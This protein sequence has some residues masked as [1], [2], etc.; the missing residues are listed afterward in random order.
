[1]MRFMKRKKNCMHDDAIPA[2]MDRAVYSC[3][4]TKISQHKVFLDNIGFFF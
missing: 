3:A 2:T 4:E 1:M